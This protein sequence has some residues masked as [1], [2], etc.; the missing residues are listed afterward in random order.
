LSAGAAAS[1]SALRAQ[2]VPAAGFIPSWPP[3]ERIALWHGLPPGAPATLPRPAPQITGKP[4]EYRDIWM[5]GT[6]QP[7]LGVFRAPRPDGRGVLV[8]PGG[9]YSFVS[10]RGEGIDVARAL[11]ARGI[12]CFVLNYRLPAEGW[13]DRA[14]VPLQ[15]AQR[16]LR[17]IRAEAR[18][19]AV[20]PAKLGVLGFSAGGH[21]A[22]SLATLHATPVYRAVDAADRQS[23]RP[24]F[25][26]LMYAV[27][28]VDPG[29]SHGGSRANLLGPVPDPAL[30]RRYAADRRITATTPPLFI[31]HAE[32]DATVP[33][34]N[35]LD[36]LG[37]ARAAAIPVEAHIFQK[38]GHGF[39]ARLPRSFP[40]SLWPDLFDRWVNALG[41]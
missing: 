6:A 32:D 15:D 13:S 39:G 21:L 37:A 7:D 8:I 16:A 26:G 27:S 17:L 14:N 3:G 34:F 4:G 38:G 33:V 35:S 30:E 10:L 28:N 1:P 24:A 31:V 40:A 25:A 36:M 12:T 11:N 2:Q 22:A 23:A 9:G 29:R 20:D 5:R 18:R 41:G 19:Y